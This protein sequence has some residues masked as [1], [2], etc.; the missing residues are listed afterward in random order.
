MVKDPCEPRIYEVG[1]DA[2]LLAS[3]TLHPSGHVKLDLSLQKGG[4]LSR[5]HNRFPVQGT[6]IAASRARKSF[7]TAWEPSK[8]PERRV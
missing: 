1:D 7:A 2:D 3:A 8:P 5:Y 4:V 6:L